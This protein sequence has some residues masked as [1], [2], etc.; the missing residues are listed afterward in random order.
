M[1]YC[2][3]EFNKFY[4]TEVVLPEMEQNELREKRELNIK[5]LNDGLLE[6]NIENGQN[7]KVSEDRIQGSMSMYTLLFKT[8]KMIMI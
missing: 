1:Y 6:Y 5:R 7:Y 8:T 4:C 3:K 2:S